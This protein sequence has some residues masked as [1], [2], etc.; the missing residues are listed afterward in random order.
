[1]E[2]FVILL[3]FVKQAAKVT[4]PMLLNNDW[5]LKTNP[6]CGKQLKK[7]QIGKKF[8]TFDGF[9]AKKYCC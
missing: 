5:S 2:N 1:L 8:L 3:A 9:T 4:T 6:I 7:M